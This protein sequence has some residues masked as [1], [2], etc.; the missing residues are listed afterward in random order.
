MG[1]SENLAVHTAW[2]EAENRHDL[3]HHGEYLHDDII[4]HQPGSEVLVGL[5]AYVT[6][7]QGLYAG[8]E[9]FSVILDDQF[10]T[11]DRVVCRWRARGTHSGEFFGLPATGKLLEFPGI[12]LWEFDYGKA[13]RG[14]SFPDFASVMMQLQP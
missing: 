6:M 10:A 4:F 7:M 1:A 3:T 14:W 2:T 11:D 13:R 8:L 9:D 5:A 12:S